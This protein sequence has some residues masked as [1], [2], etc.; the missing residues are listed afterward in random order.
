MPSFLQDAD[1][2]RTPSVTVES[3]AAS[4]TSAHNKGKKTSTIWAHTREP[5]EYEDQELLY[6][7]YCELDNKPHGAKSASSMTKHIRSIH[8][9]VQIEK[10]LSKNQVEV[11]E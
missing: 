5:L 10:V 11:N 3:A 8:K 1:S 7:S 4:R 6:C 2:S 9:T